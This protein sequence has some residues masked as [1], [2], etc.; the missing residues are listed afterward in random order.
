MSSSA[1]LDTFTG[2]FELMPSG[3]RFREL[4]TV[5]KRPDN[6]IFVISYLSRLTFKEHIL[7]KPQDVGAINNKKVAYKIQ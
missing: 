6:S 4:K 3:C 1:D 5:L 7:L 2:Q